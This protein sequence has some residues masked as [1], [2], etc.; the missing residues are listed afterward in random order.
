MERTPPASPLHHALRAATGVLHR[1]LE[2]RLDLMGLVGPALSLSRYQA[3][4][5]TFYGYYLPVEAA[6]AELMQDGLERGLAFEPQA[7][8]LARDLAALGLDA[9]A[10]VALPRCGEL[11]RLAARED[12]AGC[13][14]VLEGA[15][16]GGQVIARE[17]CQ[18]LG[19]TPGAGASFFAGRGAS[20]AERWRGSPW[21]ARRCG[22]RQW[23]SGADRR[24]GLRRVPDLRSLGRA[25]RGCGM[26]GDGTA[27][28]GVDLTNCEREPIHIPAAIQP[29]GLLLALDERSLIVTQISDNT[30]QQLGVP[31]REVLTRSLADALGPEPAGQVRAAVERGRFD[32][33]NPLAVVAHGRS[34][35]GILHR[36][37]GVTILELERSQP[38]PTGR[39]AREPLRLAL[40]RLQRAKTLQDLCRGH[41]PRDP[42]HHGLRAGDAVS[43]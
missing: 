38:P 41:R 31:L 5:R 35:D 10:V 6:V 20:T 7:A 22:H 11:P 4:L 12:V 16:L 36:H 17:V 18:R 33:T 9:G 39:G 43:V 15:S 37:D 21:M 32:E 28:P 3:V 1:R 23:A 8:L 42:A 24:R 14:Y 40:E 34:F 2:Q 30:E 26:N 29:H 27:P 19:L 25:A 13:L